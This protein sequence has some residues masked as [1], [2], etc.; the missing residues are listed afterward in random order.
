MNI[1]ITPELL[2]ALCAAQSQL[3]NVRKDENNATTLSM[4]TD[5]IRAVATQNGLSIVQSPSFH[6]NGKLS[7]KTMLCHSS[8]G[9]M[10]FQ[11]PLIVDFDPSGIQSSAHAIGAATSNMRRYALMGIF[12]IANTDHEEVVVMPNSCNAP[13]NPQWLETMAQK[14]RDGKNKETVKSY[15]LERFK[16]NREATDYIVKFF[17]GV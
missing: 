4:V 12:M 11:S 7:L 2:S 14:V 17:E 15:C 8:G 16:D 9:Y 3:T 13:V 10:E 1:N 6:E 5:H